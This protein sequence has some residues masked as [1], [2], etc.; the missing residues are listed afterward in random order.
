MSTD[1]SFLEFL[2]ELFAGLGH[3]RTRRM[4]GGHGVYFDGIMIALVADT[5]LFLKVDEVT[6]PDFLT[7]GCTPF[8]Y[9]GGGRRIEMSYWSAPESA[10]DVADEMTPWAR[11]AYAA[12]LR[13][14][15]APAASRKRK[16]KKIPKPT[17]LRASADDR[18]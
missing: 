15:N 7:A 1:T 18:D 3:V 13:K 4:F 9:E 14:A 5:R 10:M 12:A 17:H 6:K 2:E 11:R 16:P 8:V